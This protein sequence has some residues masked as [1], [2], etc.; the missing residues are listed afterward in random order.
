MRNSSIFKNYLGNKKR[1]NIKDL[2]GKILLSKPVGLE[3]ASLI[4]RPNFAFIFFYF[5]KEKFFMFFLLDQKVTKK[6]RLWISFF[7]RGGRKSLYY[8]CLQ[9]VANNF[10]S[11]LKLKFFKNVLTEILKITS[12]TSVAKTKKFKAEKIRFYLLNSSYFD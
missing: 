5:S 3:L 4:S 2:R 12:F 7:R 11:F 8:K 9:L 10:N 6:S 1:H